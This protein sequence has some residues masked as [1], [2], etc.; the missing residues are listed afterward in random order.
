MHTRPSA[1]SVDDTR[2]RQ[3]FVTLTRRSPVQLSQ[4]TR[5]AAT[6]ALCMFPVQSL[7]AVVLI[8]PL[9]PGQGVDEER[10]RLFTLMTSELEFMEDVDEVIG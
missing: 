5:L 4:P 6:A 8:S 2:P 7:A 3:V 10:Q 1:S 9:V